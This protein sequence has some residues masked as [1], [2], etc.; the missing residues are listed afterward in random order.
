MLKILPKLGFRIFSSLITILIIISLVFI[1][2]QLS[3]GNASYKYLSPELN[4]EALQKI[5]EN[6]KTESNIWEKYTAFIYN[7]FNWDFGYSLNYKEPVFDVIKPKLIFTIFFT[8]IAFSFPLIV[9]FLL[10]YRSVKKPFGWFD[11][12]IKSV[13]LVSYSTPPFVS[14][15]F[16]IYLFSY[17]LN[18]FPISGAYS[19]NYDELS[20][21]GKFIDLTKHM[22]LPILV[23]SLVEIPIYYNYLRE[24]LKN[25]VSSTF[26]LYLKS[27]GTNEKILFWKH[28][29]PNTLN[30]V[31]AIAGVE[32]GVMLGGSLIIEV[33]FGL[34]GMGRL[35]VSAI[36]TNDFPLVIGCC[37]IASAI[38]ILAGFLSDLLRIFIDRR[39][40]GGLLN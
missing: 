30:T 8:L 9:S 14:G 3:P 36:S 33:V 20:F 7:I 10:A 15:L 12:T 26:V 16:L 6:F 29:L 18:I 27:I 1:A 39:L 4:S 22:I 32:I 24:S 2:L 19:L 5:V 35:I 21:V 28:I 40:E 31:I 23:F 38:V 13:T 34:P 25:I 17:L 11:K 37:L